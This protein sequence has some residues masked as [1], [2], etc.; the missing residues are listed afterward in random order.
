ML[1]MILRKFGLKLKIAIGF[2]SLLA[3]I[4]VM[5]LIGYRSAVVNEKI[6][7]G[8][9]LYSSMTDITRSLQAAILLKRI[10]ERDVLMGRDHDT[11]HLFERGEADFNRGLEELKPLLSTEE[12]RQLYAQVVFT[13]LK[14]SSR[15]E[16][17]V[18]IYRT[19]DA[20]RAIE[21]FK[22]PEGLFVST[23]LADAMK[24]MST[25]FERRR[26]DALNRELANDAR[27]R[28]LMMMLALAGLVLGSAIACV[29]ARSIVHAI[30]GMLTMIEIISSNNLAVD[31]MARR[32]R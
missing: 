11:T 31:D 29:I 25:A 18:A 21:M 22:A 27:F 8:V 32:C 24:N 5:G 6:V 3:I 9:R 14:Y 19:G 2:G 15:N 23:A 12:D 30:Q 16:Q 17:V 7:N 1:T 4:V 26:Q 28:S 13:N 10:G 20:N